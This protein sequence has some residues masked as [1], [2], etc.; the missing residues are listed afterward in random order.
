[1]GR[2]RTPSQEAATL[3][4]ITRKLFGAISTPFSRSTSGR[5]D[6]H[7]DML[8]LLLA[9]DPDGI[10]YSVGYLNASVSKLP[11]DS[12]EEGER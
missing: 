11:P 10:W 9:S 12:N 6:N 5:T 4:R 3:R 1:L 2:A 8:W 7:T